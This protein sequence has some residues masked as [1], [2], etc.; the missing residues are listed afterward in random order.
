MRKVPGSN[1]VF[2]TDYFDKDLS[3]HFA[4]FDYEWRNIYLNMLRPLTFKALSTHHS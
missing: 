2:A 1:T 3:T 4:V